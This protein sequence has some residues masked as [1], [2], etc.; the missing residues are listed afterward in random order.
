MPLLERTDPY[1]NYLDIV[2]RALELQHL[3]GL[4]PCC[5]HYLPTAVLEDWRNDCHF[6]AQLSFYTCIVQ[7]LLKA[8]PGTSVRILPGIVG[9]YVDFLE[10]IRLLLVGDLL[11]LLIGIEAMGRNR[12]VIDFDKS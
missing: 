1:G 5:C 12:G 9:G 7:V 6:V 4:K 8:A 3:F 11:N 10:L 2:S